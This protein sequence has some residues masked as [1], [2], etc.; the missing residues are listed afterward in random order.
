M[1]S[2]LQQL[3]GH[4]LTLARGIQVLDIAKESCGI[5]PARVVFAFTSLLLAWIQARFPHLCENLL[6]A[7]VCLGPNGQQSGLRQPRA[8]LR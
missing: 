1:A 4:D 7:H 2:T 3:K 5:I 6:P 8:V